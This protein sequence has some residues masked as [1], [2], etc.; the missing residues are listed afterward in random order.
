M[1]DAPTPGLVR[2]G[3]A[4]LWLVL[5][6]AVVLA[7]TA[8]AGGRDDGDGDNTRGSTR[9]GQQTP[10]EPASAS[11]L[12]ESSP[13]DDALV[14]GGTSGPWTLEQ[15]RGNTLVIRIAEAGCL[16]FAEATSSETPHDVILASV[17][18]NNARP[19]VI[20]NGDLTSRTVKVHLQQPL[21]ARPL[22]HA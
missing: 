14:T 6:V 20:C 22:L 5:T 3:R 9:P 16:R 10:T 13:R 15:T 11:M 1:A 7:A 12:S 2:P 19:G 18:H 4:A 17:L 8:C 21:D